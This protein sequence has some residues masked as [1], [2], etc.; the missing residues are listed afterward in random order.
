MKFKKR[1]DTIGISERVAPAQRPTFHEI[2][3]L[4]AEL[5]RRAGHPGDAIQRLLGHSSAKMTQTYLDRG[6]EVQYVDAAAGLVVKP[7]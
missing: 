2:R 7:T 5:Y 1:R 4:G 3:S 6:V